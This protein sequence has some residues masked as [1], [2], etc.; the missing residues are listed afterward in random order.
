MA[1]IAPE[2]PLNKEKEISPNR[3]LVLV[4]WEDSESS[5]P[6]YDEVDLNASY[7]LPIIRTVGYLVQ[8]TETYVSVVSS[9][10]FYEDVSNKI[11]GL[12][13]IPR[14]CIKS[15]TTLRKGKPYIP[16]DPR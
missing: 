14:G 1:I 6:W 5:A 15:I 7:T 9:V 2:S 13:S 12:T 16:K 4:E 3:P 10:I 8:E 11:A